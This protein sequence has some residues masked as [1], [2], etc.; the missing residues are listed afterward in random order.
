MCAVRLGTVLDHGKMM[1][2]CDL[3]HAPH[4]DRLSVEMNGHHGTRTLRN[5]CFEFRCVQIVVFIRL[6][7][8][9]RRPVCRDRKHGR[10]IG[11]CRYDDLIPRA[12]AECCDGEYQRVEAGV[13]SDGIL[14]P[15]IGGKFFL[16]RRKFRS[17]NVP[18]RAQGTQCRRFVFRC[19]KFILTPK[20]GKIDFHTLSSPCTIRRNS[21]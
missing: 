16:E 20:C 15:R 17:H 21:S 5:R 14:R 7:K 4:I 1:L 11:V 10:N 6:N 19:V 12:D 3:H 8:D 9:R 13:Q 18:A 2:L